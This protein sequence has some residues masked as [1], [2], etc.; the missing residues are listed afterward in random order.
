MHLTLNLN[1]A[2]QPA[3]IAGGGTVAAR[4]A[5]LLLECGM[6]VTIIA[7]ALSPALSALRS[8]G[9]IKWVE[10]VCMPGDLQGAALIIAATD[11]RSVNASIAEEARQLNILVNVTDAPQQGTVTFPAVLNR[12]NLQIAV[13][14]AGNSPAF[15]VVVRDQLAGSIGEEYGKGLELL[16]E[17]REKLLTVGQAE[18]YNTNLIKALVQSGLLDKIKT[19]D[20]PAATALIESML[21]SLGVQSDKSSQPNQP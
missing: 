1:L 20:L 11:N 2:G 8:K 21:N 5:V 19:G 6:Q 10:R 4:K 17:L 15:A 12:G 3:V 18:T 16:A 7:P 9:L 14:T 13:S